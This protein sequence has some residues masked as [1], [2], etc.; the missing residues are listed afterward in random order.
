VWVEARSSLHPITAAGDGLEGW[1]DM[2]VDGDGVDLNAAPGGHLELPVAQ[3]R[4]GSAHEDRELHRRIDARRY[5]T[6][7]GDLTS[8]IVNR[9]GGYIVEGD[10][11]FMGRTQRCTDEMSVDIVEDGTIRLA[12]QSTFDIRDFGMEPPRV[13]MVRVDPHVVVR[14]EIVAARAELRDAG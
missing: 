14:V 7:E 10:L 12:G 5:P 2:E 3:L 13:L 9:N 8:M 11:M 6:I 1:L 4:S